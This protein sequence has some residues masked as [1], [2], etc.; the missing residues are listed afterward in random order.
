MQLQ[1]LYLNDIKRKVNPAVSASDLDPETVKVEIEE[2][3]F[4]IDIL[5]N[6][7]NVLDNIK[8]NKTSHNGIWISGYYGSGKSHFL[9]YLDYCM[10]PAFRDKALECFARHAKK[11]NNIEHKVPYMPVDIDNLRAWYE[12]K[13]SFES[14]MFN[15]GSSYNATADAKR[16]ITEVLWNEFNAM[17]GYNKSDIALALYLE[18]FLDEKGKFDEFKQ[19][20][21]KE[22]GF[23]WSREASF[24][25]KTELDMLL[26]LAKEIVPTYSVDAAKE[27]IKHRS[28]EISVN[29]FADE[30]AKYI[31]KKNNPNYRLV[32]FVDEISQFINGD[33]RL[34]LQLQSIV[35]EIHDHCNDQVWVAC[36]AQQDMSQIL[37]ACKISESSDDYGKIMGRFEVQAS[38]QGTKSE[39]IAQQRILAKKPEAQTELTRFFDKSASAI[40]TQFQLPTSYEGYRDKNSFIDYYPFVPYQLQLINN[41]FHSF[42]DMGFVN[43]EVQ[44]NERSV[45]RITHSIAKAKENREAEVGTFISFDQFFNDMFSNSLLP[46]GVKARQFAV[47]SAGKYDRDPAFAMRVVNVLYMICNMDD[48]NKRQFPASADNVVTLLLRDLDTP[49]TTMRDNVQ[50][51]IDHLKAN[52]VIRE[53]RPEKGS[54]YYEFF[55]E[56][57]TKMARKIENTQVDYNSQAEL[58][59]KIFTDYFGPQN[60]E[61]VGSAY[62]SIGVSTSGKRI[63]GNNA[64]IEV[65]FV[66]GSPETDPNAFSFTNTPNKLVFFMTPQYADNMQLKNL[67]HHYCKVQKFLRDTSFSPEQSKLAEQFRE[68]EKIIFESDIQ[69]MF[70]EMLDTCAVISGSSVLEKSVIGDLK[71]KQRYKAAITAHVKSVYHMAALVDGR[72]FAQTQ[73]DLKARILRRL[74]SN[75]YLLKPMCDA[76]RMVHDY[77]LMQG[78]DVTVADIT[79]TFSKAPYGWGEFPTIDIINELFRRNLFA[80]AYNNNPNVAISEVADKIVREK[81]KFTLEKAQTISQETIKA[82]NEAWKKVFNRSQAATNDA[83]ELFRMCHD[84]GNSEMNKWIDIQRGILK[85][86][87]R[88]PFSE[89]M[90]KAIELLTSWKDIREPKLFFEKVI[91]QRD[92]AAALIDTCKL[93]REFA[94]EQIGKY[95]S[96]LHFIT[97][98]SSNFELLGSEARADVDGLRAIN[99]DAEVYTH[100]QDYIRLQRAV[101]TR[102][103]TKKKELIDRVRKA[104]EKVYEQIRNIA[105]S[106]DVATDFLPDIEN[107]M[108]VVKNE[109]SLY[110]LRDMEDQSDFQAQMI[111]RIN[112]IIAERQPKPVPNPQP[113]KPG[114]KPMPKQT[115]VITLDTAIPEPLKS[116]QDVDTYLAMLKQQLMSHINNN[117]EIIIN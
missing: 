3:V 76:E 72:G 19:R 95:T 4:T 34:L 94:T 106:K 44:G 22:Q 107:K 71:G 29:N 75:E 88:Y 98:N 12:S 16:V 64:D 65:E 45:I 46:T 48:E 92:E 105:A 51:V 114:P 79:T 117:E 116:E 10:S 99:E 97:A 35:K 104:Y 59:G 31:E 93:V 57:E 27:A 5:S 30:L 8:Q 49:K 55:T 11:Y 20:L 18:K 77:V 90:N 54:V 110:L 9:K 7:F 111:D 73:Q 36:T 37:D 62:L 58:M 52:N 6:L 81:N 86:I 66:V 113:G 42:V 115:K 47:E 41:V 83:R 68:R 74:D 69:R 13:A 53:V 60:R 40:D 89:P 15:I 78:H 61:S 108:L 26:E 96:I 101:S 38:L 67:F 56:E 84:D 32:F 85:N 2:Y 102:I 91:E 112:K 24:L 43:K 28:V 100:F 33:G 21:L 82:F 23:D 70:A 109:S 25:A 17:R 39:Y 63:F 50:R 87:S 80:Y 1:E 103:D 14:V